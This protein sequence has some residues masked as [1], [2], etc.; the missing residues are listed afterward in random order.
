MTAL[1]T[2]SYI[3]FD[4]QR[5]CHTLKLQILPFVSKS[6]KQ[7][8]KNTKCLKLLVGM[9]TMFP[10]HIWTFRNIWEVLGRPWTRSE[11][12]GGSQQLKILQQLQSSLT[13][14]RRGGR[15]TL[16]LNSDSPR[17]WWR[18]WKKELFTKSVWNS[19]GW[20]HCAQLFLANRSVEKN[21]TPCSLDL[22]T[23]DFFCSPQW[24]KPSK[25]VNF[26]PS[27]VSGRK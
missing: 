26:R 12:A 1:Y 27:M 7:P 23:A 5:G 11:G 25:E 21:Q 20:G 2:Y 19:R 18:F 10:T 13:S 9:K 14:G 6:G 24:K 22:A 8:W 3:V 17:S 15:M 16:K 4:T